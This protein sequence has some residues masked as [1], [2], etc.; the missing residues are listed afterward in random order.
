M[1]ASDHSIMARAAHRIAKRVGLSDTDI[2][3]RK[4]AIHMNLSPSSPSNLDDHFAQVRENTRNQAATKIQATVKGHFA[5][6]RLEQE[7]RA[8]AATKIQALSRGRAGRRDALEKRIESDS[9]MRVPLTGP[10]EEIRSIWAEQDNKRRINNYSTE[11]LNNSWDM[12]TQLSRLQKSTIY[13]HL[14]DEPFKVGMFGLTKKISL[15]TKQ[16][17][18]QRVAGRELAEQLR[19]AYREELTKRNRDA[20]EHMNNALTLEYAADALN[21]GGTVVSMAGDASGVAAPVTRGTKFVSSM[22]S[23]FA[24]SGASIERDRAAESW[25]KSSEAYSEQ[26]MS[27][28]GNQLRQT[29]HQNRAELHNNMAVTQEVA[30]LDDQKASRK[31]FISAFIGGAISYGSE[32]ASESLRN[33]GVDGALEDAIVKPGAKVVKVA[34]DKALNKV[35]SNGKE[36]KARGIQARANV[37]EGLQKSQQIAAQRIQKAFRDHY[38]RIN[39]T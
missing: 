19:P 37:T 22:L 23:S 39:V 25:S 4:P 28:D 17:V 2:N 32:V 18:D 16:R 30:A 31:A 20:S 27:A 11:N 9:N 34:A 3:G 38:R 14:P 21:T 29:A 13:N 7:R 6:A 8:T 12:K 10:D 1:A 35:L 24:S 5:R 33:A 36:V 26:A 15:F